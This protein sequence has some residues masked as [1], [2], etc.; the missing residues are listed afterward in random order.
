MSEKSARGICC[1]KCKAPLKSLKS[2]RTCPQPNGITERDRKC[3]NCGTVVTTEE[4]VV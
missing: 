4:R 1:P 3:R 2:Q